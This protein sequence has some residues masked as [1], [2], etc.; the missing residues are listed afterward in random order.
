LVLVAI[1]SVIAE[2]QHFQDWAYE[3]PYYDTVEWYG[4]NMYEKPSYYNEMMVAEK[5]ESGAAVK[6]LP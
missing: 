4:E 5:R 1:Y 2:N 6:T 3:Y